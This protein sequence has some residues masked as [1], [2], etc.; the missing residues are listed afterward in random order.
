MKKNPKPA[1][2]ILQMYLLRFIVGISDIG[3]AIRI[4]N[5]YDCSSIQEQKCKIYGS[6]FLT[7][8]MN[9]GRCAENKIIG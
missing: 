3:L 4:K 5:I 7:Q 2:L 6:I 1:L 9:N 8:E